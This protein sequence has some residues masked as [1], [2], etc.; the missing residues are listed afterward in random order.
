[1]SQTEYQL[2]SWLPGTLLN[3]AKLPILQDFTLA[4][5]SESVATP[6]NAPRGSVLQSPP[7]FVGPHV[8]LRMVP[9]GRVGAGET[10]PASPIV[11]HSVATTSPVA[12]QP[13]ILYL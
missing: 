4:T 3:D 2:Q 13:R 7:K 5:H 12:R 10:A 9:T 11:A 6:A 8:P 1:M